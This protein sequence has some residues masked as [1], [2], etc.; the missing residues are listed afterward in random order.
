MRKTVSLKQIAAN[1]RNAQKSTGPQ[2]SN[3]QAVSKMNA[4]KHGIYSRDVL[5][6]G[7]HARE[8]ARELRALHARFWEHYKPLGPVEEMLVDKIVAAHWRLRRALKAES[9]EIALN[10]D[11]GQW[12]RSRIHPRL[13]ALE[14]TNWSMEEDPVYEMEGSALGNYIVASW[15]RKVRERVEREGELTEAAVQSVVF[16]GKPNCVTRKLEELRLKLQDNPEGLDAAALRERNKQQVLAYL[17]KQLKKLFLREEDCSE[18][19]KLEEE[20]RQAAAVLPSPEV[21]D[22]IM[23][24]ATFLERQLYR[25]MNQLERVQRMRLGE[26]VP[27]PLTM[28]VSERN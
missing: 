14:W 26:A 12:K 27:P 25:A 23:R 18:R 5:V 4:F 7:K 20:S 9:G 10:V 19:E 6:R 22:K 28:E 15:F 1:R 17:D 2:T 8:N 24:Y 13:R 21:L 3:G 16:Y 11:G